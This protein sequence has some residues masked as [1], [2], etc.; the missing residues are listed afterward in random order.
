MGTWSHLVAQGAVSVVDVDAHVEYPFAKSSAAWLALFHN[1]ATKEICAL[2]RNQRVYAIVDI[3]AGTVRA[4]GVF[5]VVRGGFLR[6]C[7]TR[8]QA[9]N[10]NN[11]FDDNDYISLATTADGIL[12]TALRSRKL[13]FREKPQFSSRLVGA[14]SLN[15]SLACSLVGA[16]ARAR[17]QI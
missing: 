3:C 14:S 8:P 17:L 16:R 5:V 13:R 10:T 4:V 7:S 11:F 9:A 2:V 6:V 1:P 15:R 12:N